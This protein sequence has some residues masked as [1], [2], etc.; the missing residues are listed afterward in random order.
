VA[1]DGRRGPDHRPHRQAL[2]L[3]GALR[4]EGHCEAEARR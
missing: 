3:A 2:A 4:D 1:R